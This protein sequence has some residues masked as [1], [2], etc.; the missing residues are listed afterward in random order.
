[1]GALKLLALDE[2]DLVV[3]SAQMQDAVTKPE[4]FDWAQRAQRF[5]LVASRFAWDAEKGGRAGSH[6]RRRTRLSFARVT[7]VQA[8]GLAPKGD[9]A[10]SLLA[11]RFISGDLPAGVIELTFSGGKALKLDVECIEVQMDDL[12]AAWETRY[13]P[14]HPAG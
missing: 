3:I 1:M 5:T 8:Q 7:R 9:E 14:Q 6:E 13:K 12:G 11:I 10:L 4:A 2:S